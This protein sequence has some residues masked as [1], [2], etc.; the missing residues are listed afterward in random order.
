MKI[1]KIISVS[2]KKIYRN[3]LGTYLGTYVGIEFLV[4]DN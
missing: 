2:V 1:D 3:I 4:G